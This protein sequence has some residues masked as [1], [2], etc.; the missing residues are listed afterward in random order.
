MDALGAN[1]RL[2]ELLEGRRWTVMQDAREAGAS[3]T[4]IGRALRM[5]KQ[6][7]ADWYNRRI[8]DRERYVPDLHDADRARAALDQ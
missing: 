1:R 5:S 4:D 6:G 2:V 7:A 8:A 3:W